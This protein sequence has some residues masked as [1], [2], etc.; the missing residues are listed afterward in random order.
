MNYRIKALE[1]PR[2]EQN[3]PEGRRRR[4]REEEA[5]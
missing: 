4:Q 1:C 2:C 3:A 5:K